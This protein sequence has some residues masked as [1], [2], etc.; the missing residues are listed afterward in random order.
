MVRLRAVEHGREAL[1][2][3]TVGVSAFVAV[4]GTVIDATGFN[5]QAVVVRQMRLGAP[6]TL[7][8]TLG[9]WPEIVLVALTVC[10]LVGAAVVRRR[11]G[12]AGRQATGVEEP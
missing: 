11:S 4:D 1:M 6:R 12:A 2:A 8:T 5:T 10:L 3:S 9:Y 7:A